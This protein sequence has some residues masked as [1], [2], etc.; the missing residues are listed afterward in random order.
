MWYIFLPP[1]SND[2][3]I[4]ETVRLLNLT[5]QKVTRV[6]TFETLRYLNMTFLEQSFAIAVDV[7]TLRL[8]FSIDNS[9]RPSLNK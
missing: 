2:S 6:V 7:F 1:E 5:S 8:T 4:V 3:P 9:L